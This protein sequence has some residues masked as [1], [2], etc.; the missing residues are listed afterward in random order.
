MLDSETTQRM[1]ALLDCRILATVLPTR[2]RGAA[3]ADALDV[4][5][6]GPTGLRYVV[7]R[8]RVPRP[9]GDFV[10]LVWDR[11]TEP[12]HLGPQAL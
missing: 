9:A 2:R 12:E 5:T 3:H 11:T 8:A 1:P 4:V 6:A 7:R 10:Y